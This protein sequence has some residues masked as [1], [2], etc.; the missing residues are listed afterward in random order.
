MKARLP[1]SLLRSV[2]R[3]FYL[4]IAA[5]PARLRKPVGTAYLLA[6]ASDTIADSAGVPSAVR[7]D[8][9]QVFRRMIEDG[10]P[11]PLPDG[12][13]SPHEGEQRLLRELPACVALLRSLHAADRADVEEVLEHITR[14]QEMDITR[15]GPL[16][17]AAQLDE[18]IFLVAG[19]V[20][21]F[22]TK[23][24]ARHLRRFARLGAGEMEWLGVS[25]GKGLQL[26]NI[27]RDLPADLAAGRCYLPGGADQSADQWQLAVERHFD[28]AFRYI[29]ALR[30]VRLRFACILP[31]WLGLRTLALLRS[32]PPLRTTR[33]VKVPREEVRR[34]LLVAWLPALSNSFLRRVR[35]DTEFLLRAGRG[36]HI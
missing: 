11:Q 25:F 23:L 29:E 22:W 1:S 4:S 34:M 7:L 24:C 20:G 28:D 27:L 15:R 17:S 6:R 21:A 12:I 30:P 33:R 16:E 32:H 14:G 10:E 26:V 35:A 9:L 19:C 13:H 8:A 36:S 3:S 5:L 2:S 31:W 18:Y